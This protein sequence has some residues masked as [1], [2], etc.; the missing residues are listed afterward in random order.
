[1]V[2]NIRSWSYTT[3]SVPESFNSVPESFNSVPKSFK[4]VPASFNYVPESFN[5]VPEIF[6][7]WGIR[8]RG[9]P[10]AGRWSRTC[11]PGRAKA[12]S[13]GSEAGSY[14]RLIEFVYH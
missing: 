1:V 5:Y 4:S 7:S 6:N 9:G 14:L 2:E 8:G 12:P 11:G 13:C 3:L 10:G